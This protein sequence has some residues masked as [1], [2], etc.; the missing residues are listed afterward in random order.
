MLKKLETAAKVFVDKRKFEPYF[1]TILTKFTP[2]S[3]TALSFRSRICGQIE[4]TSKLISS[5]W[6]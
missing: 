5:E 4:G 3:C 6:V 2:F 1:P